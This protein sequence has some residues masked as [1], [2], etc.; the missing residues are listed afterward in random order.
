MTPSPVSERRLVR[1]LQRGDAAAFDELVRLHQHKVFGLCVRLLGDRA[2]AEDVA[3]EVFLSVFLSIRNFR[4]ES[5]LSTWLYRVTRNHCLNRLKFLQ[6]RA[7]ARSQPLADENASGAAGSAASSLPR[8]DQLAEG[9]QME[10]LLER[11]IAELSD[12]HREVVVLR[13]LENLSYEEIEVITG[14]AEGTVKSR[15]HRARLELARRLAPY[16]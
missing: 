16:L 15:L 2:E 7:F 6:R 12:E 10:A 8:P 13:D 3:Q 11:A 4:G 1:A 9:R 5:L 14:L